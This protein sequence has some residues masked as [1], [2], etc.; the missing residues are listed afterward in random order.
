[1]AHFPRLAF[2]LGLRRCSL[3]FGALPA[4]SRNDRIMNDEPADPA[5]IHW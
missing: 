4:T 5:E 1:M 3:L 2:A